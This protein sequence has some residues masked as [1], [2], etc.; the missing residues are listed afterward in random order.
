M[1]T[2][3]ARLT[4]TLDVGWQEDKDD[5]NLEMK[6]DPDSQ[7]QPPETK[8]RRMFDGVEVPTLAAVRAQQAGALKNEDN[9]KVAL[10]KKEEDKK[11]ALLKNVRPT[12]T[13]APATRYLPNVDHPLRACCSQ[14]SSRTRTNLD[15]IIHSEQ[16]KTCFLP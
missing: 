1:P 14:R 13:V 2:L 8:H 11:L 7:M 12:A 15:R 9:K 5:T 4:L 3:S 10:L 16:P 6:T